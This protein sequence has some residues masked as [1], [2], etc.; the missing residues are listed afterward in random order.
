MQNIFTASKYNEPFSWTHSPLKHWSLK[1]A[2]EA[3]ILH[4][5]VWYALWVSQANFSQWREA[6]HTHLPPLH[7]ATC[8]PFLP[9]H[10]LWYPSNHKERW[11]DWVSQQEKP[12]SFYLVG[13]GFFAWLVFCL[14]R[15]INWI[16]MWSD[17][18]QSHL[19]DTLPFSKLN[20]VPTD[21]WNPTHK[22]QCPIL[23]LLQTRHTD[24]AAQKTPEQ[25]HDSVKSI[26]RA[27]AA[28][29]TRSRAFLSPTEGGILVSELKM[30]CNY[31]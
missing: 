19:T 15:E 4:L 20:S 30:L 8:L 22:T 29:Q 6:S 1:D 12:G 7:T 23:V 2:H 16:D 26:D 27:L 5:E 10:W 28:K 17:T 13:L 21:L 11:S 14:I 18:W 9:L 3:Q 31:T 25:I 24:L